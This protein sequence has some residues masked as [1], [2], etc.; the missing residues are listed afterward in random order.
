MNGPVWTLAS[1]RSL[2]KASIPITTFKIVWLAV[3]SV[4]TTSPPQSGV[5]IHMPNLSIP[6]EPVFSVKVV[7]LI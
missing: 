3:A 4:L 5:C 1:F 7:S 2:S 6:V